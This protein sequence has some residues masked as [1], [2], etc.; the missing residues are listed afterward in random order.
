MS[1]RTPKT[2]DEIIRETVPEPDSSFRPDAEQVQ[3][4]RE[5]RLALDSDEREL[6]ATVQAALAGTGVTATVER[7][8]V[9]LSGAVPDSAT[10]QR[11]LDRVQRIDGIEVVDR[12]H[13]G[14][15]S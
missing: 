7:T 6:L 13:V 15:A 10:M 9:T 4:T 5:G 12:L 11:V 14:S 8:R 1:P 2:Y 3:D